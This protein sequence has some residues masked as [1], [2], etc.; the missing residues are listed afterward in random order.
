MDGV[1]ELAGSVSPLA[2]IYFGAIALFTGG[3]VVQYKLWMLL[4]GAV[5]VWLFHRVLAKRR[6]AQGGSGLTEWDRQRFNLFLLLPP[7]IVEAFGSAHVDAFAIPWM[8]LA[9]LYR[10]QNQPKRMAVAIAMA[11]CI[12]TYPIVLLAAF[13]HRENRREAV[14]VVA[15]CLLTIAV[16]YGLFAGAGWRVFAFFT[17]MPQMEY[18]GSLEYT[19]A[20]AFGS[21]I[22]NHATLLVALAALGMA[23]ALWFTRLRHVTVE[24]KV[25]LLGLAFLLSSPVLH[26][27]YL[28]PLLPFAVVADDAATLWLAVF[29]HLIADE[30]PLD[31][32]LEY[33]PTYGLL[34]R[35]LRV[36]WVNVSTAAAVIPMNRSGS[37][38]R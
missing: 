20:K 31:M 15:V 29:S 6:A 17:K 22:S 4:N 38:S 1:E 12:K 37:S 5:S 27:W 26:P 36:Y 18:N 34:L 10:L 8:L 2:Q 35:Q 3:T 14:Q 9:W 21:V 33:V 7:L 23:S 24:R 19:L 28:L 11:T 25:C 30:V 13:L 32:Y 16:S